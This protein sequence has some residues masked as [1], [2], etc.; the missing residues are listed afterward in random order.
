MTSKQYI[1][2]LFFEYENTEA[3]TDLKEELQSN[4]DEHISCLVQKG[5]EERIAFGTAI[6]ELGD[7]TDLA[8]E[9]SLERKSGTYHIYD[10]FPGIKFTGPLRKVAYIIVSAILLLGTVFAILSEERRG[11]VMLLGAVPVGILTYLILTQESAKLRPVKEWRAVCY[12]VVAG[13]LS[14]GVVMFWLT[15]ETFIQNGEL[16]W[17]IFFIVTIFGLP[18]LIILSALLCTEKRRKKR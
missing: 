3:L 16:G 1:D 13:M 4:L 15:Y 5:L 18:S 6:A 2:S 11:A 9:I 17:L 12:G 14:L 10:D 7:I 8:S